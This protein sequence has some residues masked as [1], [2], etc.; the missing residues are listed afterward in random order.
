[1]TDKIVYFNFEGR[2]IQDGALIKTNKNLA[3]LS[4]LMAGIIYSK[5]LQSSPHEIAKALPNVKII[6]DP[7]LLNFA[8]YVFNNDAA[9]DNVPFSSETRNY[10][11]GIRLSHAFHNHKQI[12][13]IYLNRIKQT[14]Q[15]THHMRYAKIAEKKIEEKKVKII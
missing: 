1:M 5:K 9:S 8:G 12:Y 15:G 14:H 6:N 11:T 7:E 10:E 2:P 4:D 3:K 13:I